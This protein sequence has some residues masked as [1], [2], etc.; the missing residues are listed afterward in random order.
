MLVWSDKH[1]SSLVGVGI[2]SAVYEYTG[3]VDASKGVVRPTRSSEQ[4]DGQQRPDEMVYSHSINLHI[5]SFLLQKY[6]NKL[7]NEH[8]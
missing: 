7:K 5:Y 2:V 3:A 1:C 8:R 6:N 4:H